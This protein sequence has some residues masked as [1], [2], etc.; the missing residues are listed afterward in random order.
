MGTRKVNSKAVLSFASRASNLGVCQNS[1]SKADVSSPVA[2]R[3]NRLIGVATLVPISFS[4]FCYVEDK[5]NGREVGTAE[6]RCA[7]ETTLK[8]LARGIPALAEPVLPQVGFH[9]GRLTSHSL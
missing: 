7:K 4:P 6:R 8:H 1:F 2:R 3:E 5:P 9:R